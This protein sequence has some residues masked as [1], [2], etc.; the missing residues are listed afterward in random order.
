[1]IIK[2][3]G[4]EGLAEGHV[5]HVVEAADE[6]PSVWQRFMRDEDVAGVEGF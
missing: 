3:E 4:D 5:D 1:M 6:L 2:S